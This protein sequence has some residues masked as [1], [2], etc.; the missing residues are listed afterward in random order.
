MSG[1]VG[2]HNN[3]RGAVWA[4]AS[5]TAYSLSSVVGK[6]LL[7]SLGPSSL[8]FWRFSIATVV[9]WIAVLIWHRRGGP[10]PFAVPRW[11]MLVLGVVFGLMVLLGFLALDRLDASLYI[12]LVYMYPALVAVGSALLGTRSAPLTWVAL[13]VVMAG[14]VLTVPELFGGVG[15]VDGVGVALVVAQAVVFATYMIVSSRVMPRATD[16]VVAAA[17]IVL[18]ASL[19]ITPIA[20]IDGLVLPRGN[21]LV[22]EVAV[23]ALI[24]TVVSSICFFQAMR[25]IVPGA[26]AMVLTIEVALVIG[27]AVLFL[28]EEIRAIKIVGAVVVVAG[29]LLAQWAN[30]REARMANVPLPT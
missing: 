1:A 25:H 23:F 12:V 11:T 6:D 17:W 26:V 10:N 24:P 22:F 3:A 5:A 9:L 20:L 28:G 4:L 14:I 7:D 2:E 13:A 29:V 8:L 30:L 18:G 15:E 16:G 19:V 27:W 21:T